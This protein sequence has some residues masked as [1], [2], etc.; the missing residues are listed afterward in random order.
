MFWRV[1]CGLY[2]LYRCTAV[3]APCLVP[4]R[5]QVTHH[6]PTMVVSYSPAQQYFTGPG[7]ILGHYLNHM[8]HYD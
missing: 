7:T 2:G 3:S 8:F 5:V 1:A 4:P 6:S